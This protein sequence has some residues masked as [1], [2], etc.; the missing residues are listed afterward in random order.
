MATRSVRPGAGVEAIGV[1]FTDWSGA[2]WDL[3]TYA[4]FR[5]VSPTLSLTNT[6]LVP[7]TPSEQTRALE[8]LEAGIAVGAL[9]AS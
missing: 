7:A 5:I 1:A 9:A 8:Y 2:D 3:A 6:R 4:F